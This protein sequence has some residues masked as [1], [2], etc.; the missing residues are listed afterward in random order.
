MDG[1]MDR[2][3]EFVGARGTNQEVGGK[4]ETGLRY[5][6]EY[7][8]GVQRV[9]GGCRAR[10]LPPGSRVKPDFLGKQWPQVWEEGGSWEG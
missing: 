4:W 1:W 2:W 5:A 9:W 7:P 6:W 3:M 10:F 8:W